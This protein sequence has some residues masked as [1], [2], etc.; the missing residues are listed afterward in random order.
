MWFVHVLCLVSEKDPQ[1]VQYIRYALFKE[2]V[3]DASRVAF[4]TLFVL[5]YPTAQLHQCSWLSTYWK[6]VAGP[7][8]VIVSVDSLTSHVV[9]H[10]VA[11][12]LGEEQHS[13]ELGDRTSNL[14]ITSL[15]CHDAMVFNT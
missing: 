15:N 14:I 11:Q 12:V 13:C 2:A 9:R 5:L 1:H 8:C 4:N 6:L 10:K 3:D 7:H